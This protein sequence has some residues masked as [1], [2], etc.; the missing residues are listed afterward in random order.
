M[1]GWR[2]AAE[3]KNDGAIR[4]VSLILMVPQGL[5]GVKAK[6][7]ERFSA[8]L[9][10]PV[11]RLDLAK[12]LTAAPASSGEAAV[13][14]WGTEGPPPFPSRARPPKPARLPNPAILDPKALA[15]TFMDNTDMIKSLLSRFIERTEEQLDD[16]DGLIEREQWDDARRGAHTIKGSALSLGANEM[17]R[18]A[19][20]LELAFK[21]VNRQGMSAGIPALREAFTRFKGEA[22][23][24]LGAQ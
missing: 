14:V 16:F 11:K 9:E 13:G 19:A 7:A 12:I 21:T 18:C 22:A 1:D 20:R 23:F 8:C 4:G 10:K 5:P 3:I 6:A 24:T 2:L 17:G 15:E